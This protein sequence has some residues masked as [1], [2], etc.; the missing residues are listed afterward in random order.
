[1]TRLNY[2]ASQN[3]LNKEKIQRWSSA[4]LTHALGRKDLLVYL[5]NHEDRL[6]PDTLYC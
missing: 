4:H 6:I 1:M 3:I 5:G 2:I